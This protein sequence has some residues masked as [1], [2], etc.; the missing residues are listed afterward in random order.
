[1]V[2]GSRKPTFLDSDRFHGRKNRHP[3]RQTS[4]NVRPIMRFSFAYVQN[5]I[6]IHI[7]WPNAFDFSVNAF[8]FPRQFAGVN[9]WFIG[10]SCIAYKPEAWSAAEHQ[11]TTVRLL[12][13]LPKFS[14]A[15]RNEPADT[16]TNF[17]SIAR[18][19]QT[20]THWQLTAF[21]IIII[22][23][24]SYA[25]HPQTPNFKENFSFLLDAA[26]P[27]SPPLSRFYLR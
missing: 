20:R 26:W 7:R 6:S 24:V 12:P 25:F 9:Q 22:D 3:N 14:S 10:Y 1:M 16:L 5:R 4:G 21:Q 13:L 23:L 2:P 15:S 8:N 17:S 11:P 27:Q 18:G 19:T